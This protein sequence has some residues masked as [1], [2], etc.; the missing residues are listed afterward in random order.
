MDKICKHPFNSIQVQ[1]TGDIYCCCCYWTDFYSFGNIFEQSFDEIWNGDKA[2]EFRRQFIDKQYKYCK[3]DVCDPYIAPDGYNAD[4]TC[5]YPKLIEF[6]YDRR[7]NVRCV[8]CRH[9]RNA[10]EERYNREKEQRIEKNFDRIFAPVL[11]K[12]E[13]VELNSA[14]ELFS[15]PHSVEIVK[16]II[17]IN[18]YIKFRIISNGILFTK[19][20]VEELGLKDKLDSVTISIHAATEKTYNKL[21]ERG[22][23]NAVKEN[24]KYL[25]ELKNQ[26][27]LS[28][29]QLNF[30]VTSL[31]YKEMKS[32]AKYVKKLNAKAFF[33][34]YHRQIDSDELEK[35]L[36]ISRKDHPKYNELVK[37]LKDDI[38]Q[39][40]CCIVNDYLKNLKPIR[41]NIFSLFKK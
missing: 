29:L 19:Y 11:K 18:P 38:F 21:V 20:T 32:F 25:A 4:L 31:N 23:F 24:V 10:E 36:D 13:I 8:F 14:G 22:N 9:E 40:E 7:C 37:I 1:N 39:D 27:K 33:I 28:S 3:T 16:K 5:E 15:S 41:K 34:N 6:S 30:V 12:A 2:K 26:G 35:K 17:K